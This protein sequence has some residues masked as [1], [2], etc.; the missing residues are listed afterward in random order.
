MIKEFFTIS[1]LSLF[2]A[3][4][5][6]QTMGPGLFLH[7]HTNEP[8]YVSAAYWSLSPSSNALH[9]QGWVRVNPRQTKQ[10]LRGSQIGILQAYDYCG[11]YAISQSG[12][13]YGG[14]WQIAVNPVDSYNISNADL[15]YV[16]QENSARE[17]R[18]FRKWYYQR[19][20]LGDPKLHQE[21]HLRY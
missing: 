16:L 17:Q 5:T 3:S 19:N 1:V 10:I 6:G 8:V 4:A 18:G 11:Y 12:K 2:V 7:N 21:I 15:P 13:E 20:I 9:S 14:D